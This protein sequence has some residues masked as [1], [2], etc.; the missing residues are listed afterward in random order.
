MS[1]VDTVILFTVNSTECRSPTEFIQIGLF[2]ASGNREQSRQGTERFIRNFFK[3]REV[4]AVEARGKKEK[5]I[6][7]TRGEEGKSCGN[8]VT[9]EQRL[10]RADA[11]ENARWRK[12]RGESSI[13]WARRNLILAGPD[14]FARY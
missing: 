1:L 3:E 2:R 13:H 11:T 12:K 10:Q 14:G 4:N 7:R 9:E 6:T 8:K 5:Y